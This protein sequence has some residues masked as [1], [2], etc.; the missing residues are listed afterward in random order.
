MF[1]VYEIAVDLGSGGVTMG[2]DFSFQLFSLS[3]DQN[4]DY[5]VLTVNFVTQVAANASSLSV[6]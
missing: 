3:C 2:N 6:D 4:M 1:T 5:G